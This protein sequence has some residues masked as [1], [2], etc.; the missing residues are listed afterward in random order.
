MLSSLSSLSA[1][2]LAAVIYHPGKIP[3]Y[4]MADMPVCDSR[5][6]NWVVFDLDSNRIRKCDGVSTWTLTG[7][8]AW[9]TITGTL[10][11]QTDLQTALDAKEGSGT[12]SGVGA[13]ASNSWISALNDGSAP[14]C[15]QPAFSNLSGAA[16][17]AQIPDTI[18]LTNLTQIGARA[19]T[20][21]TG[22]LPVARL[23][24]GTG[25]SASTFW[26]GDGTWAAPPGGGGGGSTYVVL[27]ADRVNATTSYA[28][29]T[30][31]SWPVAAGTRYDIE[32]KFQYN[33]NA[34]TT[35]IGIS[36]TGP[37]SPTQ[38]S[39]RMTSGLTTQTIGGTTIVGNDTGVATTAST[40]TTNNSSVFEGFWSNGANAGTL[41][42]RFR[43]EVAVTNAITIKAGSWCKYTTY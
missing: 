1:F 14:T 21:T 38:T 12:F 24:G 16:T 35:G 5:H 42:M 36:W 15:T 30:D 19:I 11:A 3:A 34:T 20:D 39:G 23:N 31:L 8:A 28:N 17:D 43:S 18:T 41:Q 40:A 33:A 25:A 7:S 10:S 2:I 27:T 29:I 4:T 13:C 9:G 26:R 32:C 22:N 6:S 37:A